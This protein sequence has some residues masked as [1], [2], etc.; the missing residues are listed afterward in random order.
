M[1]RGRT[2]EG[3]RYFQ[4]KITDEDNH[5]RYTEV[6]GRNFPV[7]CTLGTTYYLPTQITMGGTIAQPAYNA[8]AH[9][10]QFDALLLTDNWQN[11]IDLG[12]LK[13]EPGE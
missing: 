5:D 4:W 11:I 2:P 6:K 13:H 1:V 7:V 8:P 3:Q 12:Y 10:R 9:Y